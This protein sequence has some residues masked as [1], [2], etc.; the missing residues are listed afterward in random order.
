MTVDNA[1]VTNLICFDSTSISDWAVWII[2]PE[3]DSWK[4]LTVVAYTS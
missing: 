2:A 1:N 3:S 4:D